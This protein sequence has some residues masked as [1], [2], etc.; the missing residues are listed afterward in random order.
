MAREGARHGAHQNVAVYRLIGM[1]ALQAFKLGAIPI[2][3]RREERAFALIQAVQSLVLQ[4]LVPGSYSD[5][6][7]TLPFRIVIISTRY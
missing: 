2:L 1:M 7:I 3:V 6:S 4:M 5:V